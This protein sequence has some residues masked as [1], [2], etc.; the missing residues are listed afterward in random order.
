MFDISQYL[1]K[2]KKIL[3]SQEFLINSVVESIKKN[4]LFDV[5]PKN[6]VIKNYSA[7]INERPLV[8]TSIFLKKKKI[9]EELAVKTDGKIKDI[10]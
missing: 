9:L 4:C 7:R 10:I 8:K 2:F 1:E 5:N 3:T 6:I